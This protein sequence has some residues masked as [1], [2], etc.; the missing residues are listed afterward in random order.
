MIL[1]AEI[2]LFAF[3]LFLV[4]S[5]IT[6]HFFKIVSKVRT[7]FRVAMAL[8]PCIIV[9]LLG[10]ATEGF[11]QSDAIWVVCLSTILVFLFLWFGYL[12]LYFIVERGISPRML[13]H[14]LEA[15]GQTL[16]MQSLEEKYSVADVVRRRVEQMVE[17]GLLE[18]KGGYQNTRCGA[19]LGKFFG[20]MKSFLNLGDGG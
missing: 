5:V 14:F 15:P 20:W 3:V 2:A 6:M 7:M 17:V 9:G 8:S 1:S 10:V 12:Q 16:S 18:K 11:I 4:I 13:I 19:I